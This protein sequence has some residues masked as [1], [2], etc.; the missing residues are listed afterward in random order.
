MVVEIIKQIQPGTEPYPEKFLTLV[1]RM[2]MEDAQR[3]AVEA[4][5][6]QAYRTA[7]QAHSGQIRQSGKPY[8]EHCY[9]V[10]LLLSEWRMDP[11]TVAAGMLHDCIEDTECTPDELTELFG[12]EITH[13][14]EGVTKLAGIKFRT[15]AEKQ[16]ENY[17]K[18]LLSV[19]KDIRVIIIKFADRLHNMRTIEYLPQI[20]QRRIALETRDVYAPLA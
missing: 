6:W 10:A 7:E 15:Q 13:L 14:V 8:F 11:I 20:K 1:D 17:M 19:A 3:K 5:L 16:A 4:F 18:M 2:T 9:N 12:L